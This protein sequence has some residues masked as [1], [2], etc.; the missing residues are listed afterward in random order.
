MNKIFKL[1]CKDDV[2]ALIRNQE[3]QDRL[4]SDY[5]FSTYGSGHPLLEILSHGGYDIRESDVEFKLYRRNTLNLSMLQTDT[6]AYTAYSKEALETVIGSARATLQTHYDELLDKADE[7]QMELLYL[8][9]LMRLRK[10]Y[11]IKPVEHTSNQWIRKN[12]IG[13]REYI[14]ERS[15]TVYRMYYRVNI[16]NEDTRPCTLYWDVTVQSPALGKPDTIAEQERKFKT[17]AEMQKY[18]DGRIKAYDKYFKEVNPPIPEPLLDH[19]T[20][21]GQLLPGYRKE[22]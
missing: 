15:N 21:A 12:I 9:M 17:E 13:D 8:M 2:M 11:D 7:V 4:W 22:E 10:R 5:D 14:C 6:D 19:F 20:Y 1:T 18:L 16:W 3:Y